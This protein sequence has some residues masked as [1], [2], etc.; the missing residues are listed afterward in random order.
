VRVGVAIVLTDESID[1]VTL[2]P[3]VE[4]RPLE[5]LFVTE[6]THIPVSRRT[7]YPGGR[8]LPREY[9]RTLDPFVAL[10][11]IATVTTRIRL[12][13]GVCLLVER[14]PLV[15]AKVTASLDRLS[16]GRFELGV[17]A[18]WNVEEM[19]NHG[20]DFGRRFGVLRE[21]VEAIR[22][23]WSDDEASYHGRYVDFDPVWSWPKPIQRPGPPVVL[24]GDG[25][26]VLERVL[27]YADAWMP[28]A[29][30]DEDRLRQRIAELQTR[31]R[32]AGRRIGVTLYNAPW[33]AAA[34][35]AY[36]RAG[37]D[38]ALVRL[39]SGGVSDVEPALDRAAALAERIGGRR[40]RS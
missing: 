25:P 26:Q 13:T 36:E 19:A 21:R 35:D 24:G 14:D 27:R 6:H 7:P 39:P 1:P 34:L 18:G 5:S 37:V 38:R 3:M 15:T 16:L 32:E 11:A 20:V 4:Q 29:S 17:G 23:L 30:G 2:G 33:D 8:E 22:R 28:R 9:A 10:S 12:G 40:P 31:A